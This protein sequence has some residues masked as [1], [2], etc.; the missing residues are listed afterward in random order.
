MFSVLVTQF[1]DPQLM[2]NE[3]SMSSSFLVSGL[4]V[5]VALC[6]P[7]AVF[8]VTQNR[9]HHKV[10]VSPTQRCLLSLG[11]IAQPAVLSHPLPEV[12]LRVSRASKTL[13]YKNL[14]LHVFV[15]AVLSIDQVLDELVFG[16]ADPF[17]LPSI[18]LSSC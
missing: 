1:P 11:T 2:P 4:S 15:L 18:K 8:V 5:S 14:I 13:T 3:R 16:L 12:I 7:T 9:L 10:V 17:Q 6:L